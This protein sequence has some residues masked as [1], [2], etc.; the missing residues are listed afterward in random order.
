MKNLMVYLSG[1]ILATVS[2]PSL[3][4]TITYFEGFEDD[5]IARRNVPDRDVGIVPNLSSPFGTINTATSGNLTIRDREVNIPGGVG[6][7]FLP[8]MPDL[9]HPNVTGAFLDFLFGGGSFV[10]LRLPT[11]SPNHKI[12]GA[13]V[14]FDV[15]NYGSDGGKLFKFI[16]SDGVT[17]RRIGDDSD[18]LGTHLFNLPTDGSATFFRIQTGTAAGAFDGLWIDNVQAELNVIPN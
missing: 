11:I 8:R 16:S 7:G 15:V 1:F 9:D 2:T 4:A 5:F 3:A 14:K 17:W 6:G 10:T 13:Y 12:L 18:T